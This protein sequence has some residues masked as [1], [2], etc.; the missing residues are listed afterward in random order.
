MIALN[1][2]SDRRRSARFAVQ[3][4]KVAYKKAGLFSFL[5]NNLNVGNPLINLGRHGAQ[6]LTPEFIRAGTNIVLQVDVPLFVGGMCF[7][8][9]VVWSAKASQKKAYRVG[10]KFLKADK[11]TA[12]RLDALRKDVFFRRTKSRAAKTAKV[13]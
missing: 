12:Q 2:K 5:S 9:A 8:G 11:E 4:S 10:V 6:F 3:G 1:K 13:G 7:K